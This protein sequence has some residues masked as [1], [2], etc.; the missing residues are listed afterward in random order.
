MKVAGG[1]NANKLFENP[2]MGGSVVLMVLAII[3]LFVTSWIQTVEGARDK[4]YIAN[5]GELRVLSQ[6]IAKKTPRKRPVVKR[7]RL[8]SFN[9][10]VKLLNVTGITC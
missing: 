8:T 6:A 9:L 10:P 4:E 1:I 7:K 5:A 2:L 3:G